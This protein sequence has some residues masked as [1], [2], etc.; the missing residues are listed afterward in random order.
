MNTNQ[1]APTTI[2]EY[3][4]NFPNDVQDIL[5]KI[6][7]TIQAAAPEAK[8]T[9]SYSMPTFTLNGRYLVYF[10]AHKQHI[11]IYP[12]PTGDAEFNAEIS[13]YIAGK[14]TVRFPFDQPIPFDLIGKMVKVSAKENA[15]RVVAKGKQK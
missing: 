2:D 12:I 6:R 11:G 8:E 1:T 15:G 10:S 3:I 7:T 14:G 13:Q 5:K 9:I 4:A